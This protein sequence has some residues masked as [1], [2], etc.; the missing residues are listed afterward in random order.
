MPSSSYQNYENNLG[1]KNPTEAMKHN[2]SDFTQAETGRAQP[3]T[4]YE[5]NNMLRRGIRDLFPENLWVQ[6]EIA[7]CKENA[8]GHCYLEL[9]EKQGDSDYL[10]ARAKAVIW[11]NV[12]I[13]L[14]EAFTQQTGSQLQAGQ[15]ILILVKPDFHELYGLSLVVLDIDPAYTVGEWA[16]RR[17]AVLSRL[18][19]EG[20]L[21]LNKELDWP[22]LPQR[23]AVISS[24][25][26]AGLEDFR[27]QLQ[28]NSGGFVIYT[29]LFPALMQGAQAESSILEALDRVLEHQELFDLVVLIRG[30]G[31][32]VDLS[33]FD[34]Y[35]LASA[36]A[37]FP[38]PLL[39]GIGHERDR[40]VADMV[41]HTSVKTPTAAAE[42][43]LS[44]LEQEDRKIEDM[45]ASLLAMGQETISA[46]VRQLQ[47]YKERIVQLS[48]AQKNRG[49]LQIQKIESELRWAARERLQQRRHC[50]D[51][52]VQTIGLLSP[53]I[54]ARQLQRLDVLKLKLEAYSPEL[55]LKR[56]FSITLHQGR[57]LHSAEGLPPGSLLETRLED[58][59]VFSKTIQKQT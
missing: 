3:K 59:R 26:A 13:F 57:I 52:A 47:F 55:Q 34:G 12:W 8:S 31:A 18:E 50:L 14:R 41:A 1:D 9:V 7:E 25:T 19:Q 36:L 54:L 42:L 16:L 48:S 53:Q 17:R 58:G 33:C 4:L 43:I 38:L 29:C 22:R 27:H 24:P 46:G 28:H 49:Q 56:G 15:K 10:R 45:A 32:T 20:V 5:L 21:E 40:S 37:Q 2:F 39:S 23:L 35:E 30:G 6:A 51:A 44:C 11:S